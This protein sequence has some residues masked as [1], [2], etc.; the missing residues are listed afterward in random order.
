MKDIYIAMLVQYI[1]VREPEDK[2][3]TKEIKPRTIR[4][5]LKNRAG[6][7]L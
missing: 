6:K 5:K 7:L 3:K 2:R 4:Q 1:D